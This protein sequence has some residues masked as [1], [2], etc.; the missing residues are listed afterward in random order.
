MTLV[1]SNYVAN[2]LAPPSEL[3]LRAI[4]TTTQTSRRLSTRT[5][6]ASHTPP[7]ARAHFTTCA[8]TSTVSL[9]SAI[10]ACCSTSNCESTSTGCLERGPAPP[11]SRGAGKDAGLRARR[12]G[13]P[14]RASKYS[15]ATE[16]GPCF[17]G[18]ESV[19]ACERACVWVCV[20]ACVRAR[21]WIREARRHVSKKANKQGGTNT[22]PDLH[23]VLSPTPLALSLSCYE[24]LI[25]LKTII[26]SCL[27]H[28][29][30]TTI[31]SSLCHHD[32][33]E[34]MPSR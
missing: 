34:P 32:N 26:R 28:P 6:P 15:D 11:L 19:S 1:R 4:K 7:H 16:R 5:F 13:P 30:V 3:W 12:G 25:V 22:H 27:P 31:I 14:P 17:W 8:P 10:C 18:D 2:P 21:E 24:T 23:L 33:L 20:C 29:I 9:R